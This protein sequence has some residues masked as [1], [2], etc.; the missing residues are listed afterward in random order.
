MGD[1]PLN[2]SKATGSKKSCGKAERLQ[3]EVST[4]IGRAEAAEAI[5]RD[6]EKAP[7]LLTVLSLQELKGMSRQKELMTKAVDSANTLI[8]EAEEAREIAS[9]LKSA[10]N[11]TWAILQKRYSLPEDVDV[12]WTT[13]EIFRK[14]PKL[15]NQMKDG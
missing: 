9:M 4:A 13:G 1:I 14:K 6:M 15:D 10:Y 3:A 12:D 5:V 8:N 2:K 11:S 7:V